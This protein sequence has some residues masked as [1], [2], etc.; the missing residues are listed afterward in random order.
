MFD[1]GFA[2]GGVSMVAV[3]NTIIRELCGLNSTDAPSD[4][5]LTDFSNEGARY[6]ALRVGKSSI[7]A[8]SCTAGEAYIIQLI[9]AHLALQALPKE[10]AQTRL[11]QSDRLR[12]DAETAIDDLTGSAKLWADILGV[13]ISR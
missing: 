13:N 11:E 3:S 8:T 6:L 9:A 10:M 2:I 12:R 5:A 4:T 1:V 7:D